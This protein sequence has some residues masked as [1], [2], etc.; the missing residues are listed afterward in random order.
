MSENQS[1]IYLRDGA[2]YWLDSRSA[3][4]QKLDDPEVSERLKLQL[5][6]RE[7]R[8]VFAAPGGAV[9]LLE[10]PVTPEE[11]RHLDQSLGFM[12]E[13]SLTDDIEDLHFA[14]L[15]LD[16]DAYSV[17]IVDRAAMQRWQELL[18]DFAG[19]V[20][21]LPEPLLLPWSPG[22]WTLIVDADTVLLRF[23]RSAGTRVERAL[24]PALLE[25]L[26]AEPPPERVVLYGEDEAA[27]IALL[28]AVTGVDLQWRR[29]G[30]AAAL[31]LRDPGAT[32]LNLLQGE[33]AP[34]LPYARWWGLWRGVAALLLLALTMHLAAGWLDLRRLE[35]ENLI[36]RSEIQSVYRQ[37]NPKGAVVDA[38]KQLRRQLSALSGG[39]NGRSFTAMLAPLGSLL[40]RNDDMVFASLSYSQRNTELRVNLL[41]SNFADVEILRAALNDAGYDATLESSS[42]SGDRVRA[43][44]RIGERT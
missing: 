8:V 44:L 26:A 5:S 11:R 38:E 2:A 28:N 15:A 14:R 7:H 27:D 18:G 24:L 40:S 29:G 6:Q 43:R 19:Q 10:L 37:V 25:S 22:E 30:L 16:S 32:S 41:A 21:W 23:G 4:A 33:F 3:Q 9:R 1:V 34:Q 17:A 35:R 12:L 20:P 36:L 31:L 39:A 13:E 42:R